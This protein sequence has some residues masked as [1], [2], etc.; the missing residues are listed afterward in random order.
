MLLPTPTWKRKQAE[1]P[2]KV[3]N[4]GYM[5][6]RGFQISVVDPKIRIL[7]WFISHILKM[8]L[9]ELQPHGWLHLGWEKFR[10]HPACLSI[11]LE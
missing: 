8:D 11:P 2:P 7:I 3:W 10:K 1:H 4:P 5:V 9:E 6:H